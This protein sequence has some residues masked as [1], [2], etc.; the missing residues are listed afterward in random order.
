MVSDYILAKQF[1][2]GT[3]KGSLNGPM[4]C[5]GNCFDNLE[6]LFRFENEGLYNEKDFKIALRKYKQFM[7]GQ[8]GDYNWK[9]KG[10]RVDCF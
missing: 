7:R 6:S 10:E 5:N 1:E 9:I 2:N 4:K 8:L 3:F